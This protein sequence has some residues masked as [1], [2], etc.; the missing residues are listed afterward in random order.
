MPHVLI[1]AD[2]DW[3]INDVC[4]ALEGPETTFTICRTGQSVTAAASGETPDLAVLDLQIANMG[5]M[6]VCMTLR[7][8]ESGGRLP[9]IKVLMLLDRMADIFLARRAGAEG[10]LVKPLDSLR[11][12]RAATTILAGGT[13]YEGLPPEAESAEPEESDGAGRDGW[14]GPRHRIGPWRRDARAVASTGHSGE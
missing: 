11:L 12:R 10:W 4:S 13:V 9:H 6:A 14:V 3:V 7:Q 1:A 5:G 8:D 2:A